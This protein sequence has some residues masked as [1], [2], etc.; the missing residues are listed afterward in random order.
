MSDFRFYLR[1]SRPRFWIYL[2]GPYLVGFAAA[3]SSLNEALYL[4][5]ALFGLYFLFPANLLVYGINDIFDYD[6]DKLN[7]KKDNYETLVS[8]QRRSRLS[9]AIFLF[10][11]PF[12]LILPFLGPDAAIAMTA[13][14]FFS[15]FYSAP[16]IRAKTKPLLD[17]IFN[18]LYILP[19]IFAYTLLSGEFP[20]LMVILAAW[21]WAMAMHA[22]SA[23]PD[24]ASDKEAGISTIATLLGKEGTTVLCAVLFLLA[25]VFADSSL[26]IVSVI[27]GVL[28]IS[29]MMV[30]LTMRSTEGVF[31]VY[32]WFPLV[33]T[34][35]GFV[36][37]WTVLWPKV[38]IA[39]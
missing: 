37:F 21:L 9:L 31:S 19:G 5:S 35:A 27:L 36:I 15:I 33:N 16:P 13:F 12:L 32:R 6:T 22:F 20:S 26:G 10:N 25:A 18:V 39:N 11:L 8:P 38:S 1:V 2:L 24:I 17:S 34:L 3:A 28:Y 30:A 7:P 14:Y 29:L 23:V 4:Q